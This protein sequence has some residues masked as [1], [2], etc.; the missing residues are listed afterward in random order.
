MTQSHCSVDESQD[1]LREDHGESS[2]WLE[3]LAPGEAV[4]RPAP[5]VG[6]LPH[7]CGTELSFRIIHDQCTG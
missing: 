6:L 7:R 2:G 3:G 5:L 1:K 4:R